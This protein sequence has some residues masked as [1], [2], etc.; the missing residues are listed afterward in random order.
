MRFEWDETKRRANL[1]DHEIDFAAVEKEETFAGE[2]V[3]RLDD[4]FEYG[5]RRFLTLGLLRGE[6]VA[7]IH[8]ETD[9]V[10]RLISVRKASKNEENI[11]FKEVKN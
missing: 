9:E 5:E 6:V 3:T 8:T 2:T 1:R 7:I 4:R 10:V 11:Y